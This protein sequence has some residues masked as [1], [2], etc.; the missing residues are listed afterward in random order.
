MRHVL[1]QLNPNARYRWLR[2]ILT[3]SNSRRSATPKSGRTSTAPRTPRLVHLRSRHLRGAGLMAPP[4]T[5]RHRQ[6]QS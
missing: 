3:P 6:S 2:H 5:Q 1:F 4:E